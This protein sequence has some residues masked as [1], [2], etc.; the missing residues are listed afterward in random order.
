MSPYVDPADLQFHLEPPP[1]PNTKLGRVIEQLKKH[2]G[3]WAC[4][5]VGPKTGVAPNR[6]ALIAAGLAVTSRS[7]EGGCRELWASWN[8][9]NA[10]KG[11]RAR[12]KPR[13]I[14]PMFPPHTEPR[15]EIF[16]VAAAAAVPSDRPWGCIRHLKLLGEEVAATVVCRN[17]TGLCDE[18]LTLAQL[19]EV[20]KVLADLPA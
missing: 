7:G 20:G 1:S 8:P 5:A 4:V 9:P 6:G 14:P 12:P 19:A 17:Q 15:S 16:P 11:P 10:K 18:C 2:P 13:E 3:Q